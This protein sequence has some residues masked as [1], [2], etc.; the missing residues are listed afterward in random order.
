MSSYQVRT[1]LRSKPAEHSGVNIDAASS[2]HLRIANTSTKSRVAGPFKAA[3]T[4]VKK[5]K[6]R[7]LALPFE[8][9]QEIHLYLTHSPIVSRDP[10]QRSYSE[11][12]LGVKRLSLLFVSRQVHQELRPIIF[13]K[14][15][16]KVPLVAA[17]EW[18]LI[19]HF[20]IDIVHIKQDA[21]PKELSEV[22][23]VPTIT[24]CY[25]IWSDSVSTHVSNSLCWA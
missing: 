8:I 13:D 10:H 25:Y 1:S 14:V 15:V 12:D 22:L 5:P 18:T 19:R 3:I 17:F 20:A 2:R 24:S 6:F 4:V 16:F 11:T 7:F 9:R 23:S 21:F